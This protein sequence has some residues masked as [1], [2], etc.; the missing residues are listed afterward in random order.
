MGFSR[1]ENE[2]SFWRMAEIGLPVGGIWN[3]LLASQAC[4]VRYH[5][6][7]CGANQREPRR[8][9]RRPR[10]AENAGLSGVV[11]TL[12]PSTHSTGRLLWSD[13]GTRVGSILAACA[14][15][16]RALALGCATWTS[17]GGAQRMPL[18][19]TELLNKWGGLWRGD[20]GQ[21]VL[22]TREGPWV[23]GAGAAM[24]RG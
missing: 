23:K 6:M 7:A 11:C 22:T 15:L 5:K 4:T 17:G 24:S 13:L 3:Q 20:G 18:L 12:H 10:T 9:F 16:G 8:S 19:P 2:F 1:S 21:S 14:M